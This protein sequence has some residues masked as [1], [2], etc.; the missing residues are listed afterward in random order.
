MSE[1]VYI[2]K[3]TGFKNRCKIGITKNPKQRIKNLQTGNS[4]KLILIFVLK[5]D[6]KIKSSQVESVIHKY[7]KEKKIWILGEWFEFK[8]DDQIVNLA[9]SMLTVGQN[10]TSI[11]KS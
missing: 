6:D 4:N 11:F 1:Y 8:N 10:C 5:V 9:E 3:D 7:F 2:I